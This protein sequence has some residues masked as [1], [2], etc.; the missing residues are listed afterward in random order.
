MK[1]I[2][3]IL[4]LIIFTLT[5][6]KHSTSEN[7]TSPEATKTEEKTSQFKY[8]KT[9]IETLF[10]HLDKAIKFGATSP[11]QLR[12]YFD[13]GEGDDHENYFIKGSNLDESNELFYN[14]SF[15]EGK[16]AYITLK[17][18]TKPSE[19]EKFLTEK[20]GESTRISEE[21]KERQ[22][23]SKSKYNIVFW[24]RPDWELNIE[25]K[26]YSPGF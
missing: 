7:T 12:Q 10:K 4:T 6:C 21:Y 14:F 19:I 3:L 13:I 22:H 16:L 25:P 17:S 23:W 26:D 15:E 1:K 5:A 2:I 8:T 24:N 11:D 20:F 18:G 9:E